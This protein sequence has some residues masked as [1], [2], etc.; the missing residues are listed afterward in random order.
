MTDSELL[1]QM[2]ELMDRKLKPL[3]TDVSELKGDVSEL[4]GDVKELKSDVAGLQSSVTV[5]ETH[6]KNLELLAEN[7]I[8]PRLQTIESCYT[9]TYKRYADGIEQLDK[10]QS[11]I[12]VMKLVMTKHSEQIQDL[13]KMA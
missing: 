1:L 4:K 8:M 6:V 10:M 2:S 3:K 9:S 7:K 12:D 5:L 13:Q 11:D